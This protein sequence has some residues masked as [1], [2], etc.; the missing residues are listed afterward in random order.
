M[1]PSMTK[2][3]K[4][5]IYNQGLLSPKVEDEVAVAERFDDI[6]LVPPDMLL[7]SPDPEVLLL[8]SWSVG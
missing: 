8:A 5:H 6:G 1:H 4:P 2:F 3:L 7:F